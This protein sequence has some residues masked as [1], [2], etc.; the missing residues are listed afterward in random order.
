MNMLEITR[1]TTNEEIEKYIKE[2]PYCSPKVV[3]AQALHERRI[4]RGEHRRKS[5][6]NR[7]KM[8]QL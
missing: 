2:N 4:K 3:R 6:D 7:S 5:G 8:P 1:H